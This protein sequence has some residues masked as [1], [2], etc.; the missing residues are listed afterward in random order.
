MILSAYALFVSLE[1]AARAASGVA[2]AALWQSMV[3]AGGLA[4]CLRLVP[5]TTATQ[6]FALWGMAFV[7]M[8]AAPLF[9][10][11]VRLLVPVGSAPAVT[12]ASAPRQ[13]LTLDARWSLAIAALWLLLALGRMTNLFLHAMQLRRIGREA[14]PAAGLGQPGLVGRRPIAICTSTLVERPCVIGFWK[15]RILI[16][17]WLLPRLTDAELRQVVLHECEHLR[18]RDDW[19]NLAQKLVLA[20]F[21]LNPGLMLAEK[22]LCREREMACDEGVVR[23]TRAPRAYAACLAALAERGL[24]AH[25]LRRA[26]ALSLGAWR[27]RPELAAR[28]YSLLRG[29]QTLAPAGRAALAVVCTGLLAAALALARCPQWIGFAD[30]ARPVATASM[31]RTHPSEESVR[32]A[33]VALPA[34]PALHRGI[35]KKI[36]APMASETARS[37]PAPVSDAM[38]STSAPT[39][40]TV[41]RPEQN[42]PVQQWVVLAVWQQTEPRSAADAQDAALRAW[43]MKFLEE[44]AREREAQARAGWLI[45]KL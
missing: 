34:R 13:W 10:L 12:I 30:P 44:Q 38:A 37:E 20:L 27:R 43:L 36:A 22:R 41:A 28:V 45:F 6:R 24:E 39:D 23:Q 2:L 4:L 31:S 3:I 11:I 16:P 25:L 19:T 35:A 33:A 8:L 32:R 29:K 5:R 7:L 14:L 15:P 26:E 21:P 42:T 40:R 1:D 9:P 17:H 18:R